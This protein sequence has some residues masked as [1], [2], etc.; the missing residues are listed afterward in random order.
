MC[1]GTLGKVR[2]GSRDPPEGLERVGGPSGRSGTGRVT[3]PKVRNRSGDSQ[4]GPGWVREPRG[5]LRWV[6]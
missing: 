5:G 2:Y 3:L 1:R 6:G 4:G